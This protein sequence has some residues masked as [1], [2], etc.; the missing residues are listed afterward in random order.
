MNIGWYSQLPQMTISLHGTIGH[1]QAY[2]QPASTM[3]NIFKLML[4]QTPDYHIPK[5]R[6]LEHFV[7]SIKNDVEPVPSGKEALRDLETIEMAYKNR[8]FM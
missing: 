1:S 7:K 5:L 6:E 2:H 4:R 8:L 3:K